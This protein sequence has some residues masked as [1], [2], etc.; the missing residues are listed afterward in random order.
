MVLMSTMFW[1]SRSEGV[2]DGVLS[3]RARARFLPLPLHFTD[4]DTESH[5]PRG[6][7]GSLFAELAA[8]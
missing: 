7:A 5:R 1:L 2:G 6:A 8:L 4:C 3:F